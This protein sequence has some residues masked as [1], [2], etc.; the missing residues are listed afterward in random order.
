MAKILKNPEKKKDSK[1]SAIEW[2]DFLLDMGLTVD[3][4]SLEIRKTLVSK[5]ILLVEP[6]LTLASQNF[7]GIYFFILS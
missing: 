4:Q 3:F 7:E 1:I 2:L 5:V 6:V